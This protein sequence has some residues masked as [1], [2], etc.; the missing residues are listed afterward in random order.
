M[1]LTDNKKANKVE[2]EIAFADIHDGEV[3]YCDEVVYIKLED[4]VQPIGGCSIVYN[5]VSLSDGSLASFDNDEAVGRF[6]EEPELIYDTDTVRYT[7]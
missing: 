1:K 4:D 6:T 5:A 2:H 7:E 3:F